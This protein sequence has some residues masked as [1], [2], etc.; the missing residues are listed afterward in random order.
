MS[1]RNSDPERLAKYKAYQKEYRERLK[2]DPDRLARYKQ[3]EK[4]R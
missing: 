4:N 3:N 2:N 1:K